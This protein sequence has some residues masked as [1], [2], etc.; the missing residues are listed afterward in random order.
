MHYI[1]I[2]HQLSAQRWEIKSLEDAAIDKG[3]EIDHFK[4]FDELLEMFDG[5]K[6]DIPE[7]YLEAVK[8]TGF[9]CVHVYDSRNID[10]W[11][12]EEDFDA[13]QTAREFFL[14]NYNSIIKVE[15]PEDALYYATK[16]KE[17]QWVK[18]R[19]LAREILDEMKDERDN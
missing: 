1:V 8:G 10:C 14:M 6:A 13:E 19:E 12:K 15:T 4:N 16:Y 9:P 18:V 5:C 11:E 17:H 3:L 7:N 2:P